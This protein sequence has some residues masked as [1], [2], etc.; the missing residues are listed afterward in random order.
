MA[1]D[2]RELL[3]GK[4]WRGIRGGHFDLRLRD[5]G[6]ILRAHQTPDENADGKEKSGDDERAEQQHGGA[7]LVAVEFRKCRMAHAVVGVRS[8]NFSVC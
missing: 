8:V 2:C 1:D 6:R 3:L 5:S 7:A 4:R